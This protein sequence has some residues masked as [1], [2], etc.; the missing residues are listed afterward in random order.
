MGNGGKSS[1][2]KNTSKNPENEK[3]KEEE[4]DDKDLELDEFEAEEKK[5]QE[6]EE[7]VNFLLYIDFCSFLNGFNMPAI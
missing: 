2:V 7:Q 5:L 4:E 1:P 3:K 6:L